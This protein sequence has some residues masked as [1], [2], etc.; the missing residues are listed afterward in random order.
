MTPTFADPMQLWL[1]IPAS[2]QDAAWQHSQS[3]Q[4]LG[5]RWQ[6]YLNQLCLRT[7]I[8][9]L[10]S[11]LTLK[12]VT[13]PSVDATPTSW[14]LVNGSVVGIH[15]KRL[16]LIATDGI[17][18]D[19]LEVQQEWVD[20]HSWAADYYLAMQINAEEGWLECWGYTTHKKLK[21]LHE[22]DAMERIYR[23]G[24]EDMVHDISALWAT[25]EFCPTA[26]TQMVI[27][28]LPELL[29][30]QAEQLIERLADSAFPRL[31][32]PFAQWGALL[33]K[34]HWRQQLW[35]QRFAALTGQ[36]F[37]SR[38]F[39]LSQYLQSAQSALERGRDVAIASGWQSLETIFGAQ[40][41]QLAFSFRGD[42]FPEGRQAKVLQLSPVLETTVRL[43]LLW[44]VEPDERLAIRAQLYP[45]EGELYLPS[46]IVFS[47]VSAQDEVLQ[48]IRSEAD[49]NY[50]QLK[51]F[52][53]PASYEFGILVQVNDLK[54]VEKFVA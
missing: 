13:W 14:E 39:S 26:N 37:V 7:F 49:N 28:P 23:I 20:I 19:E 30:D 42:E 44:Q 1:E 24:T 32:M 22:Y 43:V 38:R 54:I 4:P 34:E 18:H 51:R 6:V 3:I 29:P 31:S 5:S 12:A 16:A 41:P 10:Q 8:P 52:R 15:D 11:E 21:A 45:A 36:S 47:L 17:G 50:I 2:I 25:L 9:W 46:D 35:T 27:D 40:T 48:S 33:S 53:C